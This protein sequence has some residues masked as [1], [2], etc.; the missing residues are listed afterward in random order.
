MQLFIV[1]VYCSSLLT[2]NPKKVIHDASRGRRCRHKWLTGGGSE[3][4]ALEAL[5][6]RQTLTRS[7]HTRQDRRI[8]L[9]GHEHE[10]KLLV[11]VFQKHDE[12]I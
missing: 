11:G 7:L 5:A 12:G 1:I 6:V 2:S 9:D 4:V 3:Q 10:V 8:P